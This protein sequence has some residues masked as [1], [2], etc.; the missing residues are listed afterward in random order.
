MFETRR[1]FTIIFVSALALI[2]MNAGLPLCSRSTCTIFDC[3]RAPLRYSLFYCFDDCVCF[4]ECMSTAYFHSLRANCCCATSFPQESICC[5]LVTCCC[6]D[7]STWRRTKLRI[8]TSTLCWTMTRR[9]NMPS[10]LF[11]RHPLFD[12]ISIHVSFILFIFRR[13]D[14]FKYTIRVKLSELE[15]S[16][17]APKY[18]KE[19]YAAIQQQRSQSLAPVDSSLCICLLPPRECMC[20]LIFVIFSPSRA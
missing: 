18:W 4:A 11:A 5:E 19:T 7:A 6:G 2:S 16:P 14:E 8:S 1:R 15:D 13:P 17:R 12:P 20:S 10:T 3:L 9:L